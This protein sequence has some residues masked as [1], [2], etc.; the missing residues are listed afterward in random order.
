MKKYSLALWGWAARWLAHI[1]VFKYLEE[2]EIEITEISGTSMWAI[3]WS[4][5]SIWMS[6]KEI[7][8]FYDNLNF[9][10]LL[11]IDLKTGLL[12]WKKIEKK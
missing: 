9:V 12:K 6:S 3:I 8:S 5:I 4:L 7:I 10:K 1:W 2:K 11:D